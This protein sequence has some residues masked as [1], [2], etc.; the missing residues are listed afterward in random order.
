VCN[1]SRNRVA[2]PNATRRNEEKK[3]EQNELTIM[4]CQPGRC[5]VEKGDASETERTGEEKKK[6]RRQRQ[7]R[8]NSGPRRE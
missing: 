1:L 2:L 4:S 6:R 7:T 5:E 8:I 3:G